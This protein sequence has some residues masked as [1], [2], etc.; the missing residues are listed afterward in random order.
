MIG[1]VAIMRQVNLRTDAW[2]IAGD[3][4]I[5]SLSPPHI[6]IPLCD[7]GLSNTIIGQEGDANG[8]NGC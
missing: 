5:S 3:A 6:P 4:M 7:A 8:L 2:A 1:E